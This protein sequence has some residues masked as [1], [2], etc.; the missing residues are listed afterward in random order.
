[1]LKNNSEHPFFR[2][3]DLSC[4]FGGLKAVSQFH[5]SAQPGDILGIIGPNGAGKTTVF[6]LVT[7]V[8]RPDQ[9]K[10]LLNGD[11]VAG[12]PSHAII[13]R[14]ISRTFQNIRLFRSMTVM[15]NMLTASY[16]HAGYGLM[17]ALFRTSR[18]QEQEK[19][20]RDQA[21]GILDAFGLTSR[22]NEL[23]TSLP[24]G[25]QRKVELARA[26]VT[27]PSLLLLDEPGAGMNPSELDGLI[28]LIHWIRDSFSTTILL[29]EHRMRLVMNLCRRVTVLHFGEIIFEGNPE[30]LSGS[31][32]VVNAYFGEAHETFGN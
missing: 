21:L 31:E 3:I 17:S 30:E 15:E 28:E 10:I 25:L 14:G 20:M 27:K 7:G 4:S 18:F 23:A 9:G 12:L 13:A 8:Y 2:I 1:M 26:L 22:Q 29:I 32:T 5:V 6:N 19:A 11:D 24:Y 16:C